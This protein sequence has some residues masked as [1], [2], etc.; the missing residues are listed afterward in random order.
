MKNC[1]RRKVRLRMVRIDYQKACDMVLN[2]KIKKSME[3]YEVTD[4]ISHLLSKSLES[5]QTILM[6]GNK[7][8]DTINIQRGILQ[9]DTLYPL[10]FIIGL[11]PLSHILKK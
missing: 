11:I 8:L 9:G 1:R 7:E 6:S 4:N 5:W 2:L 3:M 10:L